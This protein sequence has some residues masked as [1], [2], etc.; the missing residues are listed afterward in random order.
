MFNDNNKHPPLL[1]EWENKLTDLAKEHHNYTNPDTQDGFNVEA[2]KKFISRI[3]EWGATDNI[4][5]QG[6][7][8][9]VA[10]LPDDA[11]DALHV[12]HRYAVKFPFA[13]E[14]QGDPLAGGKAQ[15][16]WEI[17]T[18]NQT[19]S[20]LLL[21]V[22]HH[23]NEWWVVMPVGVPPSNPDAEITEWVSDAQTTLNDYISDR[24][25]S[26]RNVVE[27]D[28]KIHLCDYGYPPDR[29]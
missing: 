7:G 27:Y 28:F 12:Q 16:S 25:F 9:L 8:R 18:W 26:K 17:R 15:N 23:G 20:D 24:E 21:P 2:H 10:Y 29:H 1:P 6:D 19:E 3:S 14:P 11:F 13:V 22:T 4:I 5:G